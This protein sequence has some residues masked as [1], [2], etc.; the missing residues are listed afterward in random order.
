MGLQCLRSLVLNNGDN[1]NAD[2]NNNFNKN[3][4]FVRI[5]HAGKAFTIELYDKICNDKNLELAFQESAME[6]VSF[7]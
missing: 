3:G 6:E 5:V 4:R 7:G 2:G 1:S